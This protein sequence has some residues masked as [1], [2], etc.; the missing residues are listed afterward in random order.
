MALEKAIRKKFSQC[1]VARRKNQKT[2]GKFCI[3]SGDA[4]RKTSVEGKLDAE[5]RK[6][7][8]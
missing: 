1:C 2:R 5:K 4:S 7:S 6:K 3:S 8:G